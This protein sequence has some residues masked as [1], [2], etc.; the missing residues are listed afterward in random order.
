MNV[1]LAGNL[2]YSVGVPACF[3]PFNHRRSVC[4]D[5]KCLRTITVEDVYSLAERHL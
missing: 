2:D 1:S 5:N 3:S 4:K